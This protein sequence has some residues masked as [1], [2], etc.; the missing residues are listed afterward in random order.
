MHDNT[1]TGAITAKLALAGGFD[2]DRARALTMMALEAIDEQMTGDWLVVRVDG[3]AKTR[4][5]IFNDLTRYHDD[6]RSYRGHV[7]TVVSDGAD[8]PWL[9]VDGWV[10]SPRR[11]VVDVRDTLGMI[12]DLDLLI[13]V[14]NETAA[15]R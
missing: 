5:D 2:L 10:I 12:R 7:V 15:T 4:Q 13:D 3:E 1:L 8:G 14:L 6:E 9:S 11:K